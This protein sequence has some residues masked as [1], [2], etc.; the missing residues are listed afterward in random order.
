VFE[1]ENNLEALMQAAGRDPGI[2]PAFYRALLETEIYVLTPDVPMKTGRR[3]SLKFQEKTNIVP[4]ESQGMKWHHAFPS[5]KRISAYVKEP[6]TLLGPPARNL[7]ELLPN[8][9]FRLNPPS[10]CQKPPPASEIGLAAGLV[11]AFLQVG[12]AFGLAV[13]STISTTEFNGVIHTLHTPLAYP[14][15][16]VDGFQRAFLAGALLLGSGGLLVLFFMPQGG[17]TATVAEADAETV[18]ALA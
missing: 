16:L 6:E 15:A 3:R 11:N 8:S 12:G 13:L 2:V 18:R 1:P 9:N 10:E 5:K 7:F 14:T 4:V 17:D